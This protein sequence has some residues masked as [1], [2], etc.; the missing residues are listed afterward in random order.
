MALG[1]NNFTSADLD[2]AYPELWGQRINDFFRSQLRFGS[3]FIDRSEELVGGGDTLHT[4]NLTEMSANT[5]SNGSQITLNSPTET[6]AD[7]TVTT[8]DEVSFLIEDREAAQVKQSFTLQ[9]RYAINAG[10]TAAAAVEDAIAT[11]FSSFSNSV[12]TSASDV[13][14]SDLRTA[15][16]TLT[17]NDVPV[18]NTNDVAWFMHPRTVW[19]Q[20]MAIDKFTLLQNTD[21]ADPVLQGEVGRLYGFPVVMTTRVPA[22]AGANVGGNGRINMLAHRDAIHWAR[23]SLPSGGDN[24]FTGQYGVRV[25][26]SYIQEYLGFLTTADIVHGE[27]E[28]RDVAGVQVKG[29]N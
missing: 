25:Q 3:F 6:S 9:E 12:G 28:N 22:E 21:G 29:S 14:D 23:L 19:G 26:T 15:I 2:V 27:V 4:V 5:K 10:Y 17:Q 24:Q 1:T 16:Q 20:I 7:L 11:L 13:Q 18:D 8:W